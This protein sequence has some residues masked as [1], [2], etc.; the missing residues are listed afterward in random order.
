MFP[1]VSR[2]SFSFILAVLLAPISAA[3][4]YTVSPGMSIQALIDQAAPGDTIQI[5]PGDYFETIKIST[6]NLHLLG[7]DFEGEHATLIGYNK[8]TVERLSNPITIEADDVICEGLHVRDFAGAGIVLKDRARVT[9]KNLDIVATEDDAIR[10]EDSTEITID[11]CVLRSGGHIG[12]SLR[13]CQ[14]VNVTRCETY[15]NALGVELLDGLQIRLDELS[16]HSNA[17]GILLANTRGAEGAADH[18]MI[19]NTRI[20]NNVAVADLTSPSTYFLAGVGMR[21]VG[22]T[23]TQVARCFVEGNSTYGIITESFPGNDDAKASPA[24][25]TYIHHNQYAGNAFAPSEAYT[26]AYS[27]IPAGDLYWDS[28][29]RRNQ[30][31]EADEPKTFPEKLIT[32]F[33]GLHTGGMNFL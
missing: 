4:T 13:R 12:L 6:P 22:A 31:Q 16:I 1:K 9:L 21:I 2:K 5:L 8:E 23:N 25:F 29:G 10:V 17:M 14:G 27:D 3:T 32:Q 19:T 18:T 20:Q 7:M 30:W 28:Q 24:E 11:G 26:T 33:G 15:R